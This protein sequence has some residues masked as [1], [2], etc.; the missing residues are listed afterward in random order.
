[1]RFGG[2]LCRLSAHPRAEFAVFYFGTVHLP[3]LESILLILS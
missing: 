1:M 2:L 3:I